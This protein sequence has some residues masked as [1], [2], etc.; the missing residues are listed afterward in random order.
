MLKWVGL[1]IF[2]IGLFLIFWK[3]KLGFIVFISG[4]LL[5][6]VVLSVERYKDWKK[7]KKEIKKEN[8]TP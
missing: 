2:L 7:F 1:I 6:I 3:A 4:T 8:L 5:L